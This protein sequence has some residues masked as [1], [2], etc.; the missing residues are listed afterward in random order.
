MPRITRTFTYIPLVS[1]SPGYDLTRYTG[2]ILIIRSHSSVD[3]VGLPPLTAVD[4][5]FP[6]YLPYRP[7]YPPALVCYLWL[8]GFTLNLY[9]TPGGG[10]YLCFG[11][12]TP[13]PPV[14]DYSGT[15]ICEPA[16]PHCQT[17]HY[18]PACLAPPTPDPRQPPP[19][20]L[21]PHI[22]VPF[23]DPD[24]AIVQPPGPQEDRP[25]LR[26]VCPSAGLP[27]TTVLTLPV[28]T[29][30]LRWRLPG[31][32]H[33]CRFTPRLDVAFCP[34]VIHVAHTAPARY[35]VWF[36]PM[37]DSIPHTLIYFV[38][39]MCSVTTVRWYYL[40]HYTLLNSGFGYYIAFGRSAPRITRYYPRFVA[41]TFTPLCPFGCWLVYSP[42]PHPAFT[43]W[44]LV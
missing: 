13:P 36:V 18:D 12:Y 19:T 37:D 7:I 29:T 5:G 31:W 30:L 14:V 28:P 2:L 38:Q 11:L 40:L 17:G 41:P 3:L 22:V 26:P 6:H 23:G 32:C 16:I 27:A 24:S 4:A 15:A 43:D 20:P 34:P 21:P 33:W 42:L 35:P 25:R 44:L 9:I 8:D 10:I 1:H 39:F